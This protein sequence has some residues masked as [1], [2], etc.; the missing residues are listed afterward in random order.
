MPPRCPQPSFSTIILN[1]CPQP[2]SSTIILNHCPQL[3]TSTT[4]P[5][6]HA[7]LPLLQLSRCRRRCRT[8]HRP[9]PTL[10]RHAALV[11]TLPTSSASPPTPAAI[12]DNS[13]QIASS[14]PA[15]VHK[16]HAHHHAST[17]RGPPTG[18][19]AIRTEKQTVIHLLKGKMFAY[20]IPAVW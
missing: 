18:P 16:H 11:S 13:A 8:N 19:L 3:F 12:V 15:G 20:A 1:H 10:L 5:S 6:H 9:H 7:P 14:T 4:M 2:L 17:E